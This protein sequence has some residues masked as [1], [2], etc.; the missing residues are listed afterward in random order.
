[1]KCQIMWN[2]VPVGPPYLMPE[3]NTPIRSCPQCMTHGMVDFACVSQNLPGDN[4]CPIGMIER[5]TEEGLA[6]IAKA[7]ERPMPRCPECGI[8]ATPCVMQAHEKGCERGRVKPLPF[9]D[10]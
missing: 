6:K 3:P 8:E 4:L 5:A 10:D 9:E 1:M 7:A 2:A